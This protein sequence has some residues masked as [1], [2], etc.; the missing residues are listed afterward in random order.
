MDTETVLQIIAMLDAKKAYYCKLANEYQDDIMYGKFLA[1]NDLSEH[2]QSYI[3][4]QL[5]A[6]EIQMGE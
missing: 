6:A 3:E 2:F 4:A 1:Y 5:S